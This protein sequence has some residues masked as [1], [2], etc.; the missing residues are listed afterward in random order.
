MHDHTMKEV[1]QTADE[2]CLDTGYDMD[3]MAHD[4][5]GP[6]HIDDMRFMIHDELKGREPIQDTEEM[7]EI[8]LKK[9]IPK[10]N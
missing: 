4:D 2:M 10:T 3:C 5:A 8:K 6:S 7:E 1:S 9:V